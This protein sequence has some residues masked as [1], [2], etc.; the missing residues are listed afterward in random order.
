MQQYAVTCL[1]AEFTNYAG[2]RVKKL[3]LEG[4][5]CFMANSSFRTTFQGG[6][7]YGKD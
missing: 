5:I 1:W 7:F 3:N 2:M 6:I 4:F